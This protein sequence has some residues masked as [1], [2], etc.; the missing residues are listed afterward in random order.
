MLLRLHFSAAL[1]VGP[2]IL[3]AATS[4]ALYALTPQ[5]EQVVYAQELHA[6][7]AD[8]YVPLADQID[9]ADAYT[10]GGQSIVAVRPA[11]NP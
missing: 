3:V 8:T 5:L 4:G 7:E 10:G 1:F 2:F 6:P 11:P 9:A